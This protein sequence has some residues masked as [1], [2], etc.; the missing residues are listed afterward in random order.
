MRNIKTLS[1]QNEMKGFCKEK[2]IL[3]YSI[4]NILPSDISITLWHLFAISLS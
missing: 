1:N 2:C 3:F 4:F